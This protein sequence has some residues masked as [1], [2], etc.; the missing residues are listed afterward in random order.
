MILLYVAWN[1]IQGNFLNKVSE[2]VENV[3]LLNPWRICHL[4]EEKICMASAHICKTKQ[5]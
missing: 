2:I 5:N 1:S 4:Y 3:D